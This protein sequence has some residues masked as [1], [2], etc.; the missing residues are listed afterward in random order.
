MKTDARADRTFKALADAQR[1]RMLDL[2]K[3]QPGI[4]VGALCARFAMSRVGAMKHLKLLERAGLVISEE[5]WRTRR[6]YLN[7]VPIQ[8]IYERWT[9]EF[10]GH[11]AKGLTALKRELE[12]GKRKR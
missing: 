9:T 8:L 4:S 12:Q 7:A 1:R 10:S 6:L 3:Q 11:F 5:E 2:I